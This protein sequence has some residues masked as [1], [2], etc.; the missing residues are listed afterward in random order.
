M[1]QCDSCLAPH[2]N[3]RHLSNVHRRKPLSDDNSILALR[4]TAQ[5]SLLSNT[6]L[7]PSDLVDISDLITLTNSPDTLFYMLCR[8]AE[9][10]AG[11]SFGGTVDF[12]DLAALI[13]CL[14]MSITLP[15]A[16]Q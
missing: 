14:C 7:R 13:D 1:P 6:R 9:T 12:S 16:C 15:R 5:G 4:Q 3:D 10:N 8:Q 2:P 11:G